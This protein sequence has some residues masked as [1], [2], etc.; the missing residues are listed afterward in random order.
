[1]DRNTSFPIITGRRTL[2]F[3]DERS[4]REA[5]FGSKDFVQRMKLDTTLDVHRGCVNTISW[6]DRGS[7]LLSGSDDKKL[8]FTNPYTKQVQASIPSG[9]RS[10]IFSA[11]FL[12]FSNDR[13]VVSCSGDGCIMFSD[14]DNPDMYGQNSFNC[15]YGTAYEVV[16]LPSDPNTFMSCGEDGN[17]RWYDLRIKTSCS[18]EECKEDVMINCRRAVT[19]ICV[20]PILPYQLAVGCSDSS[21]RIFDR[22]MLGTKLSGN[23]VGR[24][25]QG[26]LC[27][28]CP[29][30]L[31]NKYTRPTSLSYSANGQDMLVS[32]SSDY[33]YLF[34]TNARYKDH[35]EATCGAEDAGIDVLEADED[36]NDELAAG[37]PVKRLRLRGD[38]SDTGP[39]AR[40][41]SE[42]PE[43]ER[44]RSTMVQRMSEM[45]SRW[46][47][48]SSSSPRR[49]VRSGQPGVIGSSFSASS[50]ATS[51]TQSSTVVASATASTTVSTTAAALAT[52]STTKSSTMLAS[53]S[54]TVST[55]LT[56]STTPSTSAAEPVTTEASSSQAQP[57][58]RHEKFEEK[59][60]PSGAR[61][62]SR[63]QDVVPEADS[64]MQRQSGRMPE[65]DEAKE[66]K[67]R[68][69]SLGA[70]DSAIKKERGKEMDRRVHHREDEG[71]NDSKR[72]NQRAQSVP[73]AATRR[74]DEEGPESWRKGLKSRGGPTDSLEN[75]SQKGS[76]GKGREAKSYVETQKSEK[77]RRKQDEKKNEE[78]E[79]K[80]IFALGERME[81]RNPMPRLTKQDSLE[82]SRSRKK[83]ILENPPN[84]QAYTKPCPDKSQPTSSKAEET[85]E[86]GGDREEGSQGGQMEGDGGRRRVDRREEDEKEEK[87]K[88]R[89]STSSMQ[90]T[91]SGTSQSSQSMTCSESDSDEELELMGAERQKKTPHQLD[92]PTEPR[93]RVRSEAEMRLRELFKTK[94]EEREKEAEIIKNVHSP[95]IEMVYKGHRNSRTMIKEANFWGDH[96]IVSGSDCGHI[97]IWDRYTAK[98]V[99]LLE[100]DKHVVNCIQPHPV[101][102]LL[103]TSGIDYNVK[104]WAPIA[105]EP[106]FSENSAEV[107]RINELML[108]ETRDTITVPPS[109][110]LRMLASLN[111]IRGDRSRSNEPRSTS[112]SSDD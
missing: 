70:M 28:F 12:P 69:E 19:G 49:P 52:G 62:S 76:D 9:H 39:R 97:F 44:P 77:E 5:V 15:H 107:M 38:W 68:R 22:R 10:N 65:V 63:T 24:G 25:M 58:K 73:E 60:G 26:I 75:R 66:E 53:A 71:Q 96:Y 2:S 72:K 35:H 17:V 103:A 57:S 29:P 37:N 48:E 16:T 18:K 87:R 30:H 55:T 27:R 31:Q 23:H 91:E 11:K 106:Y 105:P 81:D 90:S 109:F 93:Q 43:G 1:M 92:T 7:L 79:K 6:N 88:S 98:L 111:H 46:L 110:M 45:L 112:D 56:G 95:S 47:E 84:V 74:K 36:D 50:T 100:G 51:A 32:Y 40:P 94:K 34:G 13:Q 8:C 99:M 54:T 82:H 20:N 42:Q 59:V 85:K 80:G 78:E 104:L 33:I 86:Q 67:T 64:K 102:P 41:R 3:R 101:D 83:S 21:I 61:D 89:S 14:L 108:E 4:I